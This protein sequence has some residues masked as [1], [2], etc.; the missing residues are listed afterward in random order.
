M[1]PKFTL[2]PWQVWPTHWAGGSNSVNI[3]GINTVWIDS[4]RGELAYIKPNGQRIDELVYAD[5]RLIA[6]APDG[7]DAAKL[8][9]RWHNEADGHTDAPNQPQ[10][11]QVYAAMKAFVE[12]VEGV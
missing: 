11:E 3:K 12:K 6:A 9:L 5:A 1:K 7:Y 2:G 4:P 10:Y 8:F